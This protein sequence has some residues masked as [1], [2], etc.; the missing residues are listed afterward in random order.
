M[1]DSLAGMALILEYMASSKKSISQLVDQIPRYSIYKTKVECK[2]QEESEDLIEKT[3]K[4]FRQDNFDIDLTDGAKIY[5]QDGTLHVRPSNT[6][7]IIRII[8]EGKTEE[9][10]QK[11][12]E[13]LKAK[14]A[15]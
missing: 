10:A 13:D 6:E 2:D 14:L 9:S 8:S 3:I 11:L 4:I 15:S 5:T 7:P 1:R 12:A